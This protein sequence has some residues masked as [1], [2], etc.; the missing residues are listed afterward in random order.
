MRRRSRIWQEPPAKAT[1]T[2]DGK[3]TV[4]N[5]PADQLTTVGEAGDT[6][7]RSALV[8]IRVTG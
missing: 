4:V 7:E 3:S 5:A 8:E 2:A 1:L 6:G